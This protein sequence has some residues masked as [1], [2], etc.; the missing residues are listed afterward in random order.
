MRSAL[1]VVDLHPAGPALG[2]HAAEPEVVLARPV[3][4]TLEARR[5]IF[6]LSAHPLSVSIRRIERRIWVENRS[7]P[8]R[9]A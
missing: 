9:Y 3:N 7:A 4:E 6:S 5:Q 8:L 1:N 2:V